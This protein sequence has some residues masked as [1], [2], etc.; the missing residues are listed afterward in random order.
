MKRLLTTAAALAMMAPA[1]YADGHAA[2]TIGVSNT[3]Q[4]NGWREQMICAMRAQ[5]AAEGDVE[6]LIVAHR[7]TD[8]AGQLEDL[9]NLIEAGVDAIVLNPANPEALNSALDAAIAA[10]IVVV[11]VD[12]GV[13]AEGAYILSN[14]QEEYAYL[15]ARWLFEQIGGEGDVVY[16]RGIAGVSADTD[17]DNGFQRALAEYPNVNVIHEVFTGWQQDQGKQQMFDFLATGIPFDGVWTSGIDN[18]IVDAFVESG[19]PLVP[20]VGAD[21]AGFV[22]YLAETEGLEGAAVTNPGSVGGAGIALAV[23]ILNG[24]APD[25]TTVLVDPVLWENTTAEGQEV[26]AGALNPDLDPEWPVSVSIPGW[27]DY[28]MADIIACEG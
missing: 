28:S 14:N 26:I 7:N 16:M 18:V 4:G 20:I 13:T 19:A 1:A 2:Y 6:G 27:T 8:A 17:R 24:D 10:G 25:E 11:A 21:N 12:A 22:Q 23:D 15:G 3:V 5:A 9:N